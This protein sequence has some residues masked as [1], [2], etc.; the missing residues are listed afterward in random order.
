MAQCKVQTMGTKGSDCTAAPLHL[1]RWLFWYKAGEGKWV[2][3]CHGKWGERHG[4]SQEKQNR[5]IADIPGSSYSDYQQ[6]A[7]GSSCRWLRIEQF[8]WRSMSIMLCQVGMAKCKD[9]FP[10]PTCL[11]APLHPAKLQCADAQFLCFLEENNTYACASRCPTQLCRVCHLDW[12]QGTWG[13]WIS[14]PLPHAKPCGGWAKSNSE[15]KP[16]LSRVSDQRSP[17][18]SLTRTKVTFKWKFVYFWNDYSGWLKSLH[19]CWEAN[20]VIK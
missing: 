7:V 5:R 14:H 11:D 9:V 8:N 18:L 10:E 20:S 3:D 16:Y 6:P 17:G 13:G 2:P 1:P 4:A 15:A 12:G 19:R